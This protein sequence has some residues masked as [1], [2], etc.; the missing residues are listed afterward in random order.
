ML[1]RSGFVEL[2][3]VDL[4]LAG[5]EKWYQLNS[6]AQVAALVVPDVLCTADPSHTHTHNGCHGHQVEAS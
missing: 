3:G 4:E 6:S 2:A 5:K 1:H